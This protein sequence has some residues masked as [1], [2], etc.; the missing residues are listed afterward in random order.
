VNRKREK[1]TYS[2]MFKSG[3]IAEYA[4]TKEVPINYR[5]QEDLEFEREKQKMEQK[6]KIMMK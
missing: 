6:I 3:K 4:E 5:T 1:D 2:K